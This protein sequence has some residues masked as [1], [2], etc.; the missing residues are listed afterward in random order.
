MMS[1][2]QKGQRKIA[3]FLTKQ[4]EDKTTDGWT[5]PRLRVGATGS[6]QGSWR[7]NP[8]E[9]PALETKGTPGPDSFLGP[10]S[11]WQPQAWAFSSAPGAKKV[12]I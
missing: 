11:L 9:E 5:P 6:L 12:W 2:Q 8:R 4:N 1:G 10:T 3:I 7:L